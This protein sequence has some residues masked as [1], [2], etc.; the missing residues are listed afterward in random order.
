MSILLMLSEKLTKMR[1][2]VLKH[3]FDLAFFTFHVEI[4]KFSLIS[5]KH[6]RGN[7]QVET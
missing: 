7:R 5:F 2:N 1:V 4:L 3:I 6:S